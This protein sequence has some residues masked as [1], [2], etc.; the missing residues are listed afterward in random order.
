VIAR[1]LD[2]FFIVLSFL[3]AC[4]SILKRKDGYL[5]ARLSEGDKAPVFSLS[6]DGD[7][8]VSLDDGKGKVTVLYFYPKDDTPGCTKQACAFRDNLEEFS[9]LDALV[10]GVSKDPV[11]RHEKFKTKYELNFPLL[12]D[13]QGEVCDAYGVWVE[14]NMYGRKYMGIERSTFVIDEKGTVRKI[15]RKVKV[16]GHVEEVKEFIETLRAQAAA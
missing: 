16:P 2:I 10:L 5:M 9:R 14:K 1:E 7:K 4:R 8:T 3:I 11:V 12:S 6:A 13:E 15:W